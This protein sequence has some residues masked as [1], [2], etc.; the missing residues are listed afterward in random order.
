MVRCLQLATR[1]V[2]GARYDKGSPGARRA[3][4]AAGMVKAATTV[5]LLLGVSTLVAA[6]AKHAEHGHDLRD[7]HRGGKGHFNAQ[8]MCANSTNQPECHRRVEVC[9]AVHRRSWQRG[10]TQEDLTSCARQL[11]IRLPEDTENN[12]QHFRNW[13]RENQELKR[14]LFA[15]IH[16]GMFHSDGSI[17]RPAVVEKMMAMMS[18]EDEPQ[19]LQELLDRVNTCPESSSRRDFYRCVFLG[20]A[21]P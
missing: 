15:C 20:C 8:V 3:S 21:T 16:Q 5:L 2:P 4:R 12:H 17:N 14:Q 18:G 10:K 6:S 11:K 1:P 9:R 13:A 19:L 7:N